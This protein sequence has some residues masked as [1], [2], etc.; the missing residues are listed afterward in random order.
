MQAIFEMKYLDVSWYNED[1]ILSIKESSSSLNVEFDDELQHFLCYTEIYPKADGIR[2]GQ[3][4]FRYLKNNLI[5]PYIKGADDTKIPLKK[6]TDKD[7]GKEWWIEANFWIAKDKRWESKTYRTAGKITVVLQSQICQ[8][9]IGSSEF[10]AKQLNRYLSDFK[11]DLWELILDEHSY[12]TGKA[13]ITQSGGINEETIHLINHIISHTQQILK[14]PKSELR[15]NQELK[16]RKMVKPVSRTFMEIATKGDSN[17]LTSRATNPIFNVPENRYILFALERIYRIVRQLVAI[18]QNKKNRFELAIEKLNER[19]HSFGN[20][21]PIDK[22]LVRKDLEAIKKLYNIEHVN[23]T[24]KGELKNLINDKDQFTELNK[25]YLKITGKTS[26]GKSYFVGV[27]R[28]LNDVWF[29]RVAGERNVF[30]NLGNEHYQNLLEEGFE[31][32]TDARLDYSTGVS[33]NDVRWHNYKLIKLKNIEVIGGVNFEKR[34]ENFKKMKELAIALNAKN[35]IKELS[36][37]E[38]EEQEREKRSIQ[39]RLKIHEDEHKKAEQVYEFLEP[40]L[41]KIKVIL[42]QFKRLNI[43]PSPTFPNSMT[44][45]QNPHY[46]AIHSG[47]KALRELTNL[48]D[49]DLLLSLEQVDEIGL[50]NMPLLYERWCLLQIIKVLVQNYHYSPSHDWKRKLLKIALTNNRNESLDFTNNNVGRH[51]KLWY[52]SKLSNGKTPDFVMDVTCNKKDK[53]K[54]LK[55]R[56]VMDAKFYS[57]DVLQR[58]GG[59]SA[60]IRELYESKDYSEGGKNAVFILHPSQNAIDEKI[61]PQIW[62]D[63]SYFGELKMFNWDLGLRKKNYHKYGA[64]CANPVLRIRYLSN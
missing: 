25:W 52:E 64:I 60:V 36:K 15:E 35:W 50:I 37:K 13:K 61:S 18:S 39:N 42:D 11:S 20:T 26:D 5:A 48:S 34:K 1:T 8:V 38:K 63:N 23:N 27:K 28:Q 32:K 53:R 54:D 43:K 7:T 3:L 62:G 45:V 22:N 10:T 58:R 12:V 41:K 51:I 6:I 16:P 46:Q 49:D 57:D 56:F 2:L 14:N 4:A 40:K 9:N 33:K 55:Q 29:E 31:Y 44:F 24:L 21:K 19:Y 30:L 17:F 47:Y 59:I